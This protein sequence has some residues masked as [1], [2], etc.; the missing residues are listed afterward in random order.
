[1]AGEGDVLQPPKV[2][3]IPHGSAA[4]PLGWVQGRNALPGELFINSI[5]GQYCVSFGGGE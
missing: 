4:L 2:A 3:S 1:M 5:V